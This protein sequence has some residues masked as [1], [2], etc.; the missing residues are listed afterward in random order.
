MLMTQLR[1]GLV[2]ISIS[3]VA[4]S[5]P[6]RN[7]NGNGSGGS[8]SGDGGGGCENTCSADLHSVVDCN[9]NVVTTCPDDQACGDGM[10]SAPCEAAANGSK[11]TIGCDYYTVDPDIITRAAG[12]VLRGVR[13]EH[14]EH[15]ESRSPSIAEARADDRR[16]RAHAERATAQGITYAPL[17][18]G[19]LQPGQVA[20]LFLAQTGFL[21][22]KLSRGRHRRR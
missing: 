11:S 2:I 17:P 9:G 21:G 12:C 6:R 3:L 22:I 7:D 18:N 14:M 19:Q 15:A 16:L 5:P 13:R 4:C 1:L 8:D 20:I 10:C